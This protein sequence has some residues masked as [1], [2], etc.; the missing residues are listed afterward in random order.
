MIFYTCR[1]VD[2]Q[3]RVTALA[4]RDET[5]AEQRVSYFD[6]LDWHHATGA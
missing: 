5:G 1:P 6:F 2:E 4:M 3:H